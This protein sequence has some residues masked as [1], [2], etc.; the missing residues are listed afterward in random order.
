VRA[1]VATD[2]GRR[3]RASMASRLAKAKFN[4]YFAKTLLRDSEARDLYM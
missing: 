4:A 1:S 2:L 3:R